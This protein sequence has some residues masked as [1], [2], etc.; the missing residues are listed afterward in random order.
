[1]PFSL[2]S[3]WAAVVGIVVVSWAR[4]G[5]L[6]VEGFHKRMLEEKRVSE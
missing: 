1:M 4:F 3:M 5:Y 6:Q 2:N